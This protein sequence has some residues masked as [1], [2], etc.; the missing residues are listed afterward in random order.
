MRV[1]RHCGRDFPDHVQHCTHDGT[2]LSDQNPVNNDATLDGGNEFEHH[3]PTAPFEWR[4]GNGEPDAPEDCGLD[5][6]NVQTKSGGDFQ[7]RDPTTPFEW[8]ADGEADE[9]PD[10]EIERQDTVVRDVKQ[11]DVGE[12]SGQESPDVTRPL[13]WHG[14]DAAGAPEGSGGEFVEYDTPSPWEAVDVQVEYSDPTPRAG[15]AVG[16]EAPLSSDTPTPWNS[17]APGS[18]D[19]PARSST[20]VVRDGDNGVTGSEFDHS[21]TFIDSSEVVALLQGE[22]DAALQSLDGEVS[23]RSRDTDVEI[24]PFGGETENEQ[25]SPFHVGQTLGTYRLIKPLGEG[26]AGLVYL[27][28]HTGIGRKVA[29]KILRPELSLDS[30]TVRRFLEEARAVNR[31]RH[32]HIVQITDLVEEG[33]AY[34]FVVMEYLEG[35]SLKDVLVESGYL[36]LQRC[37]KVAIQIADAMAAVHGAGFVHR[38]LKPANIFLTKRRGRPD[39]IKLLDFGVAKL[40]EPEGRVD[41]TRAGLVFGSPGFIAPEC[42]VGAPADHRSDIYALGVVLY[43][44]ITGEPVFRAPTARAV[45]LR[46]ITASPRKP[47]SVARQPVPRILDQLVLRCLEKEPLLRPKSMS[48]V[49]SELRKVAAVVGIDLEETTEHSVS[50]WRALERLPT[51]VLLFLASLVFLGMVLFVRSLCIDAGETSSQTT[52]APTVQTDADTASPGRVD[53]AQPLETDQRVIED[54]TTVE[55]VPLP[56]EEE[57]TPGSG[58]DLIKPVR[59]GPSSPSPSKKEKARVEVT[60]SPRKAHGSRS[61]KTGSR[62]TVRPPKTTKRRSKKPKKDILLDPF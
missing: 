19:S 52:E 23:R 51:G 24:A 46:H 27:A 56:W 21:P 20:V 54:S 58:D 34:K 44:T 50:R 33:V 5:N 28:E 49:A 11:P 13:A 30:D 42:L 7:H 9:D 47:S 57:E 18:G 29:L 22:V 16:R 15:E 59:E 61:R 4:G 8:R 32:D 6:D 2:S 17:A 43:Q 10:D 62:R 40:L 53:V 37:L 48:Q 26:G 1:C 35:R 31:I 45:M 36:P 39:H 14:Q 60:P 25:I 3:D 12:A 38:D 41:I 55:N